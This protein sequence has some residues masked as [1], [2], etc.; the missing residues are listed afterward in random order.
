MLVITNERLSEKL[1]RIAE[2]EQRPIEAILETLLANYPDSPPA[3]IDSGDAIQKYRAKLYAKARDYWQQTGD[4][5][6]QQLTDAELDEQFW[7]F[8]AEDIPR[9]KSDKHLV[10]ILPG[11]GIRHAE[12]I[13]RMISSS[14]KTA[15]A[16]HADDIL[17]TEFA[18]YLLKRMQDSDGTNENS[19]R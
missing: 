16:D 10:E 17:N 4:I 6:R 11:S 3:E 1:T 12:A 19:D 5:V 8:D 18:D 9:L 13:N 14:S 15:I 2:Q 7:L